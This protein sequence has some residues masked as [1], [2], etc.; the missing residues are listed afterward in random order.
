[1][2]AVVS[3]VVGSLATVGLLAAVGAFGDDDEPAA[4]TTTVVAVAGDT[5]SAATRLAAGAADSLLLVRV[6]GDTGVRTGTGVCVGQSG[7]VL[8]SDVLVGDADEVVV[9]TSSGA[10]TSAR[11]RGRDPVTDLALLELDAAVD[12]AKVA[13]AVPTP[14]DDVY[15]VGAPAPGQDA[16]WVSHGVVSSV[17]AMAT[18][19]SG[20]ALT[21]LIETDAAAADAA[22]GGALLDADGH[23]VGIVVWPAPGRAGAL[24]V[25]IG[26]AAEVAQQ[27]QRTGW[28]ARAWV[29]LRGVDGEDGV[30]VTSL[31]EQGPASRA[32][33]EV[34][35]LVTS[36]A[37]RDVTT[38]TQLLGIVRAHD[39]G[40]VVTIVARRGDDVVSVEATL[41]TKPRE[42]ATATS[43]PDGP[44]Q[45]AAAPG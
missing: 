27:L 11:V 36:V 35:D 25:P 4:A 1:M 15:A 10:E 29:G 42:Q 44:S 39:P 26:V 24:A 13:P 21:G 33:I 43:L 37:D 2:L 8:T 20:V 45:P 9:V 12:V 23:V 32:G 30:A 31:T 41:G 6:H 14:G 16:P 19:E 38:M 40:D 28:V 22:A 17:D 34:G 18:R 7:L 3:G 5:D